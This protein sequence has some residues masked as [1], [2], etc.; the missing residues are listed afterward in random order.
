MSKIIAGLALLVSFHV[1]AIENEVHQQI[2]QLFERLNLAYQELDV[3]AASAT[4]SNDGLYISTGKELDLN[5]GNPGQ[6]YFKEWF[7]SLK[8]NQKY[9]DI[10]FRVK[11]REQLASDIV[12][13]TGYYRI[14][15]FDKQGHATASNYGKF[16]NINRLVNEQWINWA[17]AF[18]SNGENSEYWDAAKPIENLRYD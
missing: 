1:T 10:N 18:E 17:D 12:V 3:E 11:K 5:I 7:A 8:Q 15:V 9:A 13:D 4:Y 6:V 14:R 2:N 16:L